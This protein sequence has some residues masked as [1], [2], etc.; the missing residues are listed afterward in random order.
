MNE[1]SELPQTADSD[2]P[3]SDQPPNEP[4][5]HL[6]LETLLAQLDSDPQS[7]LS[8][9]EAQHWARLFDA[10]RAIPGWRADEA[11]SQ[12]GTAMKAQHFFSMS[13]ILGREN[14][15]IGDEV[16]Y[17][18]EVDRRSGKDAAVRAE[19]ATGTDR[20]GG[21][22]E[23]IAGGATGP[24]RTR[25]RGGGAR[26]GPRARGGETIEREKERRRHPCG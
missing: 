7:G 21:A 17:F 16:R 10:D 5:H 18:V 14:P 20:P 6:P 26:R 3:G 15:R 2:A 1:D 13:S 8:E 22:E 11:A 9:A 12:G 24:A 19:R 23:A 25:V 4:A